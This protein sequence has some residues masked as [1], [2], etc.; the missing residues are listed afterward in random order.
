MPA[1]MTRSRQDYLKALYALAPPAAGRGPRAAVAP[2]RLA[3]RLGGSAPS[4]THMLARLARERLVTHAPR[5]GAWLT[6]RGRRE[7]LRVLR[8]HRIL[9]TFLVRVLGFDWAEVHADA[10]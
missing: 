7:A 8:R 2:S 4:V 9:E 5:A 10:E 1:T 3:Q 6:A